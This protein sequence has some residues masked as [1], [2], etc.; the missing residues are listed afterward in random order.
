[1]ARKCWFK[2]NERWM[3]WNWTA[4]RY[5]REEK[6]R[7]GESDETEEKKMFWLMK[8]HLKTRK[9]GRKRKLRRFEEDFGLKEW[10]K[11]LKI[12]NFMVNH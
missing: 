2:G 1:M 7:V 8:K 10:K 3:N 11:R 12:C 9:V 6:K 5:R 4:Q